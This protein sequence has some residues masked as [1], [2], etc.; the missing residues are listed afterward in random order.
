MFPSHV[1]FCDTMC[2]CCITRDSDHDFSVEESATDSL[3]PLIKDISE[4]KIFVQDEA[5]IL[6][7]NPKARVD[8]KLASP[9]DYIGKY[10]VKPP[11]A[12]GSGDSDAGSESLPGLVPDLDSSDDERASRRRSGWQKTP[13]LLLQPIVF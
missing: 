11:E 2:L 7:S 9:A 13:N 4:L 6:S 10:V 8:A 5:A 1:H 3:R 12:P